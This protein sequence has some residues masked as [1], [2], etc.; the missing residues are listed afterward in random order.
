MHAAQLGTW[1][2]GTF[3]A[4]LTPAACAEL[5]NAS[6]PRSLP[7]GTVVMRQ[8]ETSDFVYV[9]KS[10]R[11]RS[12]AC[13]KITAL[14]DNGHEGLLGVRVSGDLIGELGVVRAAP[15]TATVTICAPT[16]VHAFRREDFLDV[17]SRHP[18]AWLAMSSTIADRL[19]WA[20]QHRL[21][22]AGLDVLTRVAR[23]LVM[24]ADR[25]GRP[26]PHG[27]ELGVP[28]SQEEL[29]QLIGAHRDAVVKAIS[30]LRRQNVVETGYRCITIIQPRNLRRHAQLIF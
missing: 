25:H 10:I 17:L 27:L 23:M 2:A 30:E 3:A 24:L 22:F 13:A 9:L 28:L 21:E 7:T 18:D 15:R 16:L 26:V 12:I 6:I 20:N 8:G 5:L 11:R 14:L 1:P 4:R 19:D 29:G